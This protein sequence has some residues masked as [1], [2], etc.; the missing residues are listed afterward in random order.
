MLIILQ[1]MFINSQEVIFFLIQD[2]LSIEN[3]YKSICERVM[4]EIEPKVTADMYQNIFSTICTGKV[5]DKLNVII[6][7]MKLSE[8]KNLVRNASM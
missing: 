2:I 8:V 7:K 3:L 4:T 6:E 1:N 5:K